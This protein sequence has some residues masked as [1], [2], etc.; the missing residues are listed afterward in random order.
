MERPGRAHRLFP[1][2]RRKIGML[3]AANSSEKLID[4][5]NDSDRDSHSALL[6]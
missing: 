3:F 2:V 6:T 5:M 4:V 1:N